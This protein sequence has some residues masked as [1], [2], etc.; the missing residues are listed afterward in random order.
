MSKRSARGDRTQVNLSTPP[1]HNTIT[2]GNVPVF[3]RI[4]G[5]E[6]NQTVHG[7]PRKVFTGQ[8]GPR[9]LEDVSFVTC[10]FSCHKIYE[11]YYGSMWVW[12]E[13][14]WEWAGTLFV[15]RTKADGIH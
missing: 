1:S 5:N 9:A 2:R 12:D 3:L 10:N 13:K 7:L 15:L 14:Q 11:A 6:N 4:H 8:G